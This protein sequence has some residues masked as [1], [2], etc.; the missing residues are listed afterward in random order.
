MFANKGDVVYCISSSGKSENILRAAQAAR[1][2][3]C[4]LVTFSGFDKENPLRSM[5]DFN[6]YVPANAY[7]YVE[8]LHNFIIH[9]ILDVIMFCNDGIDIFNKNQPFS[10]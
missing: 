4:T 7:G 2:K 3:G 10:K 8:L 9:C 1:A 6:F 5:G